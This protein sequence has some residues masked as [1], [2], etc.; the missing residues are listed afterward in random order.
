MFHS[1]ADFQHVF[2]GS[3]IRT[4][5]QQLVR[6][7]TRPAKGI[8]LDVLLID[9]L[10]GREVALELK[11]LT[12]SWQ[13]V[14]R[15][16]SFDLLSQGAQDIR[17]YDCIKDISRVEVFVDH[18]LKVMALSF[19]DQWTDEDLHHAHTVGSAAAQF[20]I[21]EG[22]TISGLRSWGPHTGLAH[23]RTA[24][25]RSCSWAPTHANCRR[26]DE[27]FRFLVV[28]F[29]ICSS[30]STAK[31][32][33]TQ[34][35]DRRPVRVPEGFVAAGMRSAL[36]QLLG[37]HHEDAAGLADIGELVQ[38]SSKVATLRRGWQPCLEAIARAS[39]M[40][41]TKS[42]ETG[43]P[44]LVRPGGLRLD[45]VGVDVLEE[46]EATVAVW[47]LEHCDVGVVAV[48]ADG[49]VGPLSTDRVT[50]ERR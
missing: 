38:M 19:V 12:A 16:E 43:L 35:A 27:L 31:E 13:G 10:A 45:R 30:P 44:D 47:R 49:G 37:E 17:A 29:A 23:S 25:I 18:R 1:E 28:A 5:P 40:S 41:S 22:A 9:P 48:E 6:L 2:R 33:G 20:R 21:H 11:Y 39:S 15:L 32:P 34:V 24:R 26:D 4:G 36:L 14:A 42:V 7:K 8:Y 50:S 3:P 46:L